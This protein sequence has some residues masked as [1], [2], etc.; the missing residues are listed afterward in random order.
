MKTFPF[1]FSSCFRRCHCIKVRTCSL[2]SLETR[3]LLS[4]SAGAFPLPTAEAASTI[5]T[6]VSDIVNSA[7]GLI[8][9]REAISYAG[10]GG[11][12]TFSPSMN[13]KIFSLT[14]GQN[15]IDAD[16]A[17]DASAL[18]QG[19]TINGNADIDGNGFVGP[20]DYA[21]LSS[22]WFAVEG[23]ANWD[24]SCDIDD[25]G[26]I[27]P[28]DLSYISV[29]WFKS[30]DDPDFVNPSRAAA[31]PDGNT[32]VQ[33]QTASS[34]NMPE[35]L[36][37]LSAVSEPTEDCQI[38]KTG[39]RNFGDFYYLPA[40][41]IPESTRAAVVNANPFYLEVW[42]TDNGSKGEFLSSLQFQLNYDPSQ[43]I[44]VE[45]E[46]IYAG[47]Y[48][49]AEFDF[50]D[51]AQTCIKDVQVTWLFSPSQ[52]WDLIK[53]ITTGENAWLLAR[54][55]VLLDTSCDTTPAIAVS[56]VTDPVSP[57]V[58]GY[59]YVRTGDTV[60][61]PE[62]KIETVDLPSYSRFLAHSPDIDGNGVISTGDWG[63]LFDA[64]HTM[65]GDDGWNEECDITG[66]GYIDDDDL[67]WLVDN[68]FQAW[69]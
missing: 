56:G 27:G 20:G 31:L 16:V 45:L 38:L 49:L 64:W 18:N 8:S 44:S 25:D 50:Y 5:V 66:D 35:V 6:T 42:V 19:I 67:S 32:A 46:D 41:E 47:E 17:V 51:R 11:V 24:A 40:D 28:G 65:P 60:S 36:L 10:N 39:L 62:S 29:N 57:F 58:S 55:T 14:Q 15:T 7:D 34:E 4:V 43:V 13:E 59:Y 37:T 1:L 48:A 22:H 54:F 53:P 69:P 63:L 26:F 61:V 33:L 30:V 2:E 9:L 23:G 12:V 68:W 21:I 52:N 3:A